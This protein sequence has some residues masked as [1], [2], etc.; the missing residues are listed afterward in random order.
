MLI[1]TFIKIY[2]FRHP[3][4]S[5]N[6]Y[7]CMY[8]FVIVLILEA[9]SI[10][11]TKFLDKMI[12]YGVFAVLYSSSITYLLIDTYYYGAL[13]ISSNLYIIMKRSL[14]NTN[15]LYPKRF[16]ASIF[17]A[18]LNL[19]L[20][21]LFL[22]RSLEN[23][24]KGLSTPILIILAS[25]VGLFL[26]YYMVRK[27]TEIYKAND[28]EGTQCRRMLMRV[29]SFLFFLFALFLGLYAAYF[30]TQ[31]QQSRNKTPPE[32]RYSSP[33]SSISPCY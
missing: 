30:Y 19:G 13:Q 28:G 7:N 4:I 3:D 18:L 22:R 12:F 20:L 11:L 8:V 1:L 17:F 29:F 9:I 14:K 23:G 32:S 16:V 6:A 31:R 26:T 2:Q 10:Y 5:F 24:A 27:I 33:P 15:I 25:N 21:I